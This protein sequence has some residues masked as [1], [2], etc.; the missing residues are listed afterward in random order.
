VGRARFALACAVLAGGLANL[1]YLGGPPGVD[2]PSHLFQTW[3]YSHAGFNLWNN[4][5]Y[6]GRY[7]FVTYSVLYYPVASVV[8]QA[9]ATAVAAAVLAGSFAAVSRREWGGAATGPSLTFAA[10][11]PFILMVGG[12]YPFMAGAAAGGAALVCL[13]R[14]RRLGFGVALLASFGFSPLAFA[15]LLAVLAAVLLG[16]AHPG[17][18]LRHH[19]AAFGAVVVVFLVAVLMERAFPSGAWYPYDLTDAAIVFG[20]SLV[21]LYITGSSQ[22]AR[23]LRMLFACYLALNM[24][25]FLLKGP[26]GS[27]SSRLFV[28]A[29]APLLWLAANVSRERS[30]L[31]VLPLLATALA[32]QV[33]PFVR[34]AYSSWGDPASEAAYWAPAERLLAAHP[35]PEHR[36]EVVATRGH[37][38]AYYLAKRGI[39]LA[40]G[41]FRQD[42][43]PQNGPLYSDNLTGYGYRRWLQS[44]GVHYVL[45][46]D[47]DLDYS[48]T[49]EAA[50]LRSGQAGLARIAHTPH[51]TMYALR[52]PTPLVSPPAG[53]KALLINLAQGRVVLWTSAPG[54]YLVRIRSSP[55]WVASPSLTCV[56]SSANGMTTVTTPTGGY[57]RLTIRPRLDTMADTV[58]GGGSGC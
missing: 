7:E 56:G 46:P 9:L 26:I 30:R 6:A 49:R 32:L 33:G 16:Q 15:L 19:R 39:P 47:A 10:T 48:A 5:W 24:V 11:A 55:Y 3:L 29:G 35:D 25:A 36:V 43:F 53:A 4:Y 2:L 17:V 34:D 12:L 28:I 51:W 8:G 14:R 22:R 52:H 13:Q 41:W 23:S 40:R 44:L 37:W 31:V 54:R 38:E 1:V 27:N 42:D 58:G 21:G 20:F 18:A 50:L 45:L 57:V